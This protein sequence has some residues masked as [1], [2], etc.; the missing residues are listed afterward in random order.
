LGTADI[1]GGNLGIG[2]S[3]PGARL[4]VAGGGLIGYAGTQA[5][6]SNGLAVFGNVG[7]GTTSPDF[8][9]DVAGGGRFSCAAD[10][11][12]ANNVT[13][14]SDVAEV[15]DTDEQLEKGD[16][17]RITN[18]HRVG[19]TTEA[20]DTVIGVYSTSPGILVGGGTT[21]IGDDQELNLPQGKVP[22]ALAGR[23]PT[24][25]SLENGSIAVGD[26]L[27]ASS[28]PGVAMKATKAGNV[29][30]KALESYDN[31]DSKVVGKVMVFV[32]TGYFSG[33]RVADI[34]ASLN[35]E[36]SNQLEAEDPSLVTEPDPVSVLLSY[37]V[38][39]KKQAGQ[40]PSLSELLT[41]RVT[42]GIEI[43]TP[44]LTAQEV[45]T[46][47]ISSL[48]T[49]NI[50]IEITKTN[51]LIVKEKEAS[52]AAV[53]VD[54]IGNA[55]FA[56]EIKAKKV[57]ADTIVGFEVLTNNLLSLTDKV[58]GLT[59]TAS[60]SAAP[61]T[62][63][64]VSE[65]SAG[66]AHIGLDMNVIGLLS[67][68]GGLVVDQNAHFK[69]ESLFDRLVT[70]ISDV[71]FKGRVIFENSPRFNKDTA[72]LAIIKK[73]ANAVYVPFQN[74]YEQN[75]FVSISVTLPKNGDEGTQTAL[76]QTILTGDI[77]YIV[78]S[79]TPS[80]FVIK[81]NKEAPSDIPFSW[82]ALA[83]KDATTNTSPDGAVSQPAQTTQPAAPTTT[84][85]VTLEPVQEELPTPTSVPVESPTPTPTVEPSPSVSPTPTPTVEPS[86]SVSPTPTP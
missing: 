85:S 40:N 65:L 25:V 13:S 75:P 2:T 80:G 63:A 38:L 86:P 1:F 52:Q 36:G 58:Q 55:T 23:V 49:K 29:I 78:T 79:L 48:P 59:V 31:P 28:I 14:C 71:I 76:E 57:T 60:Q 15:Y 35:P 19:K 46:E 45:A 50:T 69:G 12:N 4:A 64:T 32:Q 39:Q 24:K 16:V 17:V 10:F 51:R 84:Q 33:V 44:K 9:L 7:I 62:T 41:D 73:G 83:V 47:T 26:W 61:S 37:L 82:T 5:A 3:S 18:E 34:L 21:R 42:A 54:S 68:A 56:G 67:A 20:Y 43:V 11:A 8:K 53:V 81:L 27:T 30:G 74:A 70:F 6:P 77:K 22:V 66:S 72:G